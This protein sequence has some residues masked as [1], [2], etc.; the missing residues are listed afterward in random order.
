MQAAKKSF[1]SE[2]DPAFRGQYEP[3]EPHGSAGGQAK[4]QEAIHARG[5]RMQQS[6]TDILVKKV[7][8]ISQKSEQVK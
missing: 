3:G 7:Q 8:R 5:R 6:I 1:E 2:R 4:K